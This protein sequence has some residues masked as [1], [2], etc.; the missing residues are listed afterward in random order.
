MSLYYVSY[1]IFHNHHWP[2]QI[3][4]P[5]RSILE[6]IL[7]FNFSKRIDMD[8][9]RSVFSSLI[10][11][12]KRGLKIIKKWTFQEHITG[13]IRPYCK[14]SCFPLAF[15]FCYFF[16]FI[17]TFF[18]QWISN[19]KT[20]RLISTCLEQWKKITFVSGLIWVDRLWY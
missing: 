14:I 17:Y 8:I 18:L 2:A 7:F 6:V 3:F 5:K 20:I 15:R 10:K 16:K 19:E 1:V 11:C 9:I 4:W 13:K 12:T